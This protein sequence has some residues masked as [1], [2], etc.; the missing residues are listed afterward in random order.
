MSFQALLV[1]GVISSVGL[2]VSLFIAGEAFANED[3]IRD[4]AKF[5]ALLSLLPAL[6]LIVV[7]TSFPSFKRVLVGDVKIDDESELFCSNPCGLKKHQ[8]VLTL[9]IN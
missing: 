2:T 5:G 9:F 4:Q 8:P 1:V 3:G 7:T 6:L